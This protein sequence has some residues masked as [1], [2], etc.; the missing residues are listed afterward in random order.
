VS[1]T[2]LG[3]LLARQGLKADARL[4]LEQGLAISD[5]LVKLDPSNAQWKADLDWLKGRLASLK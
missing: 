3:D 2:N 1:Y 5:K 4:R